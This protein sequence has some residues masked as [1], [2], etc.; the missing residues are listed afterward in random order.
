MDMNPGPIE[1][2]IDELVLE[3]VD[4][5]DRLAVADALRGELARLLAAGGLPGLQE[6]DAE[7][8]H[9]NRGTLQLRAGTLPRDTG[10]AVAQAVYRGIGR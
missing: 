4:P 8:S 5:G 2:H 9:L 7:G 10:A 1:L 3:G 6:A